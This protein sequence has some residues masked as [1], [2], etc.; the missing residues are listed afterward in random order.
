[1]KFSGTPHMSSF[2]LHEA[3]KKISLRGGITND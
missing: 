2:V 1:M 3:E